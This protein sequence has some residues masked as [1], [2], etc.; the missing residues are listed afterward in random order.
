MLTGAALP[1]TLLL[2]EVCWDLSFLHAGTMHGALIQGPAFTTNSNPSRG[3]LGWRLLPLPL[4]HSLLHSLPLCDTA[5]L[6]SWIVI[7]WDKC[8]QDVPKQV[9]CWDKEYLEVAANNFG[10]WMLLLCFHLIIFSGLGRGESPPFVTLA[11][12]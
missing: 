7:Y 6:G 10:L 11:Y 2:R 3:L 1:V 5:K 9:F 8:S 4:L 12:T